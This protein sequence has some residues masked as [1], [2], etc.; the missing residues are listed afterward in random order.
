MAVLTEAEGRRLLVGG[1]FRKLDGGKGGLSMPSPACSSLL[2]FAGARTRRRMKQTV[3]SKSRMR[4]LSEGVDSKITGGKTTGSS[5]PGKE[6]T[7]LPINK[8]P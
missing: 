6:R 1:G 3:E 4:V 2:A 8:L 5:G 7:R